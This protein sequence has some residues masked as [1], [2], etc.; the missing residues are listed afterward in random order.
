MNLRYPIYDLNI[1]ESFDY[2]THD[3]GIAPVS[4]RRTEAVPRMLRASAPLEKVRH[5]I[6]DHALLPLRH[7]HEDKMTSVEILQD[8]MNCECWTATGPCERHTHVASNYTDA[9]LIEGKLVPQRQ[10][11]LRDRLFEII[12]GRRHAGTL[13]RLPF[14]KAPAFITEQRFVSMSQDFNERLETLAQEVEDFQDE[15]DSACLPDLTEIVVDLG[16]ANVRLQ[17]RVAALEDR[18]G[19]L[20]MF[21][22]S[23]EPL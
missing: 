22:G 2:P 18:L 10:I 3:Q 23:K 13:M 15:V 21:F 16:E 1:G 19:R 6:H 7:G 8:V 5:A 14:S 11:T 12:V 20:E 17:E 9:L 4:G